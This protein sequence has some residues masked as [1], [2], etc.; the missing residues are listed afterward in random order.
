[1]SDE[2]TTSVSPWLPVIGRSLAY[3]CLNKAIE[4]EPKKFEDVLTKVNFLQGLGL[5]QKDAAEAA[6]SSANSVR[7]LRQRK[8]ANN[9]NPKK[10]TR[11]SR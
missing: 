11:R 4:R 7:V 9:G 6:G 5:S 8:K 2:E 10:K 3:L 1:M